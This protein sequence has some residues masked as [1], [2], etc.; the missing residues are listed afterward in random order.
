VYLAGVCAYATTRRWLLL[1]LI[2]MLPLFIALGIARLLVVALPEAIASPM[3]AVHAFYQWLL[4]AVLVF[5]AARWRSSGGRAAARAVA[6]AGAGVLLVWLLAPLYH[7][8]A[9]ARSGT[10]LADPQGAL[11]LLPAFQV[12]LYVA[13]WIAG[14]V[15]AGWRRFIAGLAMLAV[16]QAAA[17]AGLLALTT[18][19]G[20]SASVRDV[21]AW[22]IV[23]PI[24]IVA[25]VINLGRARR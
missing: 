10:P 22:A 5:G 19:A 21:R 24:L 13:L 17:M 11:A 6:G 2:A 14:F 4:A 16:T 8:L 3:L 12:G 9:M 1:G 18:Y 15:A 25:T 23:A 20:I 7:G